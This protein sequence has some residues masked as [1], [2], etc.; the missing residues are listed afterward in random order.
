MKNIA[1]VVLGISIA[2]GAAVAK[3]KELKLVAASEVNFEAMMPD[4]P[5]GPK[6]GTVSGDRTKGAHITLVKLPPGMTSP[7]H[8]HSHEVEGIVLQGT[9]KHWAEGKTQAE[10][11][12]LPAGSYFLQPAKLKHSSA[13]EGTTECIM[14][15]IQKGKLDMQPVEPPKEKAKK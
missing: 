7:V 4:M 5:Q 9:V 3:E 6:L 12:A 2:A 14:A 1:F 15:V 10:A 11:K 8:I 13:C